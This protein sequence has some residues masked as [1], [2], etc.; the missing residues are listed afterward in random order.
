MGF[1]SSHF[2]LMLHDYTSYSA[3]WHLCSVLHCAALC[4]KCC[5]YHPTD[6][7]GRSNAENVETCSNASQNAEN[8]CSLKMIERVQ[9][10]WPLETPP[11]INVSQQQ[12]HVSKTKLKNPT[13]SQRSPTRSITY[14]RRV[15]KAAQQRRQKSCCKAIDGDGCRKTCSATPCNGCFRRE[16]KSSTSQGLE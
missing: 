6:Q 9:N 5:S 8:Y 3:Q 15:Q 2:E 7:C 16:V 12:R 14:S 10:D 11:F 4:R 13:L 1:D